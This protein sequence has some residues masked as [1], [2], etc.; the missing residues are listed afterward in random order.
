MVDR[1]ACDTA[2]GNANGNAR[3][4]SEDAHIAGK[5][6][7]Q[8]AMLQREPAIRHYLQYW[9]KP[10][11]ALGDRQCPYLVLPV[12]RYCRPS[13]RFAGRF[14]DRA[15]CDVATGWFDSRAFYR[16]VPVLGANEGASFS[17]AIEITAA[18]LSVRGVAAHN[19]ALVIYHMP[20]LSTGIMPGGSNAL[21]AALYRQ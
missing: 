9:P 8:P 18:V 16:P 21:V 20:F 15:L 12:F 6:A 1:R 7:F 2:N 10:A 11:N 5:I 3:Q 14:W 4:C 19:M 17:R 13:R